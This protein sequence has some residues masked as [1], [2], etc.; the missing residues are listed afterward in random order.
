MAFLYSD[1]IIK[2]DKKD[3]KK[4]IETYMPLDLVKEYNVIKENIM[5][6]KLEFSINKIAVNS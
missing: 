6:T 2:Q 1:P 5:S 3:A 4:M